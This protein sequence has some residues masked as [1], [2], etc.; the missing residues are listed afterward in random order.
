[1]M[2]GVKDEEKSI[3]PTTTYNY[4]QLP[5]TTAN[6]KQEGLGECKKEYPV[7]NNIC[8]AAIFCILNHS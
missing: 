7:P 3:L 8:M 6:K 1:M 2:I 5:T 4:L